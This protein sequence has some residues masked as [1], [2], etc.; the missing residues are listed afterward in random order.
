MQ[1]FRESIGFV[2]A[3]RTAV[4][5]ND[6]LNSG[7]DVPWP[8]VGFVSVTAFTATVKAAAAE[9]IVASSQAWKAW[10]AEVQAV[11]PPLSPAVFFVLECSAVFWQEVA[12]NEG[13]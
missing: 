3:D 11:R 12:D 6:I 10:A 13:I 4:T 5:L 8:R 7:D 9:D 1:T 2:G